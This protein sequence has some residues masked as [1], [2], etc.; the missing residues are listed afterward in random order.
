M[1]FDEVDD[2]VVGWENG[3]CEGSD[4]EVVIVNNCLSGYIVICRVSVVG[5]VGIIDSTIGI[6]C[7]SGVGMRLSCAGDGVVSG[8]GVSYGI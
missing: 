4:I 1:R 6:S 2:G 7:E 3:C 8:I 5:S